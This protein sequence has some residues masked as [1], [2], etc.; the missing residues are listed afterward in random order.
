MITQGSWRDG[1]QSVSTLKCGKWVELPFN[2]ECM[3]MSLPFCTNIT[4]TTSYSGDFFCLG[5][6]FFYICPPELSKESFYFHSE[7]FNHRC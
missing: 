5:K 7:V 2:L 3:Y 1:L 6:V 4:L